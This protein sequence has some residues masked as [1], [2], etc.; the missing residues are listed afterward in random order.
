M[1]KN[2]FPKSPRLASYRTN[3]SV[4][5]GVVIATTAAIIINI[6]SRNSKFYKKEKR[7]CSGSRTFKN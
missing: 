5:I 7:N 3:K 4:I 2:H 1:N 6:I